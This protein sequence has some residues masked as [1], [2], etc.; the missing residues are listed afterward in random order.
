M[1]NSARKYGLFPPCFAPFSGQEKRPE[2]VREHPDSDI[3]VVNIQ[4][5]S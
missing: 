3:Q 5:I 4:S 1:V 2:A